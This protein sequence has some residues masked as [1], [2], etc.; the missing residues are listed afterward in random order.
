MKK[1]IEKSIVFLACLIPASVLAYKYFYDLDGLGAEP[2]EFL[3]KATGIW[4]LRFL[5]I[6]FAITT[7]RVLLDINLARY[8]R[9]FGLFAFCYATLHLVVYIVFEQ[10]YDFNEIFKEI[11]SKKHLFFGFTAF[12]LMFPLV[13][14]SSKWFMYK[15]KKK[16][17]LLHRIS[18]A[19]YLL[20]FLHFFL[21]V[22]SDITEPV[23]YITIF[24]N[25][26]II[27]KLPY[28]LKKYTRFID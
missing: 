8:R 25:L 9:M 15:L 4:S 19:I 7:I 21:I 27:R 2:I 28:L 26:I 22:K 20:G 1:I 18:Y 5:L 3:L 11:T 12:L 16:W 24:V 6:G 14:T 23:I 10:D 13:V 17:F